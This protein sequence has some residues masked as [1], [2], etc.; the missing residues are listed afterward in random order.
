MPLR[1]A[2]ELT[3]KLLETSKLEF[4]EKNKI[5]RENNLGC[6]RLCLKIQKFI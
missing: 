4:Q 5:K 1:L 2:L 3:I 6:Y